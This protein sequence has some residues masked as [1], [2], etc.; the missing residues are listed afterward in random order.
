MD[1]LMDSCSID[2][3]YPFH[4]E[5]DEWEVRSWSLPSTNELQGPSMMAYFVWQLKLHK[6]LGGTIDTVVRP[7]IAW[8]TSL[9]ST[10]RYVSSCATN[11]DHH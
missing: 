4:L 5:D 7:I 10:K 1:Q 11:P 3:D 6:I 2:I 9:R 8:K